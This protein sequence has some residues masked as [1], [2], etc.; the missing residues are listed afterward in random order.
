MKTNLA[1]T[2]GNGLTVAGKH[3]IA[4]HF[5]TALRTRDWDLLRS[6][7]TEDAVWTLPGK[8]TISGEATGAEAVIR[9]AQKIAASG[10]S[11][12]LNHV[13]YGQYGVALS[14]HNQARRGELVLDEHLATVCSL[15]DGKIAAID[16]YLSDVEMVNAF[17]TA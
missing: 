6:I 2:P 10:A 16:T 15:R 14:I 7:L 11:L 8:N 1:N 4:D 12:E 5:L 17:F 3:E 13:L 9:R